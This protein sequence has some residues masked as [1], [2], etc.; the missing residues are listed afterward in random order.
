MDQPGPLRRIA[1]YRRV[2]GHLLWASWKAW[3]DPIPEEHLQKYCC[4]VGYPRSGHSLIGAMLTAHPDAMVSHELDALQYVAAGCSRRQLFQLIRARDL[5]FA[6]REGQWTQYKYAV[7]GQWQGRIRSLRVIG[8]KKGGL[9]SEK[10]SRRP[11]LVD[12]LEATVG[13]PVHYVHIVRNPYDNISTMARRARSSVGEQVERYFR[14]VAACD[15]VRGRTE[16]TRWFDGS[17][18]ELIAAPEPLLERLASFLGLT[19]EP[20][21]IEACAG[22]VFDSPSRSRDKIEWP[23]SVRREVAARAADQPQLAGYSFKD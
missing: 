6:E 13:L 17:H 12:K 20:D 1:H 4:F 5:W 23:D 19:P 16:P 21:W 8:D 2:P 14:M 11:E 7:P 10:F 18:E 3:M 15:A 9:T 22:V